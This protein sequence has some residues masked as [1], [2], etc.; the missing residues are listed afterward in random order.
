MI[1]DW[2]VTQ[3]LQVL[4]I[5]IP[6]I[7]ASL[8]GSWGIREIVDLV[9]RRNLQTQQA[10]M[11]KNLQSQKAEIDRQLELTKTECQRDIQ[12]QLKTA[13]LYKVYPELHRALKETPT[14]LVVLPNCLVNRQ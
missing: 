1:I 7:L 13:S 12:T 4:H 5:N 3:V 10:G 11:Q 6:T 8:C 2:I 14:I 9:K